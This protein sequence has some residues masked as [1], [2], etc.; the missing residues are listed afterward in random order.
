MSLLRILFF[1]SSAS[2]FSKPADYYFYVLVPAVIAIE[3]F[4]FVDAFL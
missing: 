3:E 4:S 2:F 1:L